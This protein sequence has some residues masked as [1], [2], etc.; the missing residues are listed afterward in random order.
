MNIIIFFSLTFKEGEKSLNV[1]NT[2]GEVTLDHLKEDVRY[3]VVVIAVSS[4]GLGPSD[5]LVTQAVKGSPMPGR[6]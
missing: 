6:L 2:V 5:P 1:S 3:K 4:A